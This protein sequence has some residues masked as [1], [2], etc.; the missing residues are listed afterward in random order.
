MVK[1]MFKR[2]LLIVVCLAVGLATVACTS[3]TISPREEFKGVF[4]SKEY[5]DEES[6]VIGVV[7]KELTG[8]DIYGIYKSYNVIGELT[9]DELNGLNYSYS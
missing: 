5:A 4:S 8:D 3:E 1:T 7:S 2:F 9:E 6:A